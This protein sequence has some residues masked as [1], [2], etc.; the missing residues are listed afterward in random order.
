M[1]AVQTAYGSRLP[2]LALGM[3]VNQELHNA[4]SRVLE[5]STAIGYGRAV[6]AGAEDNG[7]TATPSALFEGVTIK[8][9]TVVGDAADTFEEGATL[10]LCRL[11]V[12]AVQASKAVDKGDQAY[13]TSAGAWT[14]V[15]TDN[16]A[17]VGATFDG[18]TSAAGLVPLRIK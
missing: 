12:I 10:P 6:F 13:V 4:T 5:D 17:I 3:I 18:T 9:V 16:T 7:V 14:D 8:D 2:A 1:A 15:A 11:G